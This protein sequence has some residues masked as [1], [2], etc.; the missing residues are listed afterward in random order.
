MFYYVQE[1]EKSSPDAIY[2][3]EITFKNTFDNVTVRHHK[4][5]FAIDNL[6]AY[7]YICH[8]LVVK[9]SL[10]DKVGKLDSDLDGSQD[11]DFVL[12]LAEETEHFVRIP[13]VLYYWRAHEGSVAE[14]TGAKNYAV[15]AGIMA[16]SNH[17]KRKNISA[18]V[19][20]SMVLPSI[21]RIKYE[22]TH[23]PLV[24]IIVPNKDQKEVLKV[25]I[26]SIF[27]KTTYNNFEIIIV[28][29]NSTD[30]KTFEYYKELEKNPK[31]TIAYYP[32]DF[33]YSLICNFG[34]T[35][36]KGEQVI[37]LN[38]DVEVI[39]PEWIEEMLM[40]NQRD[41]VA[42]T[43]SMLYYPNDTIQHAGVI[44]GIGGVAGHSHKYFARGHHGY[45]GRLAF[46]QNFSAVTGA[47]MMIKS[48]VFKSLNGFDETF[49]VAFN[50]ID[51]CMRVK[52]TG[53]LICWTPYSELYHH[54]SI[55]RGDDNKAEH[56]ERFHG[57]IKEFNQKWM[58]ELLNGDKYYNLNLTLSKE[59]F[60]CIN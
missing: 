24:S 23:T 47:C 42:V 40:Y 57:E 48:S 22:L 19:D 28:E 54:E 53:K 26:D 36:A 37:M 33:N 20:S 32:A 34:F 18:T 45:M 52:E 12:R 60:S 59:D 14:S 29:N 11:H 9:K 56:L 8:F 15:E 10:L 50:D 5:E 38:N 6:R 31:I 25:C 49:K 1:I 2:C 16:V 43:G 30:N 44:L 3:D 17:L 41:D 58:H 51:F 4:P 46:A 27:E 35:F 39:T 13:K 7:N 21:Y 55:S